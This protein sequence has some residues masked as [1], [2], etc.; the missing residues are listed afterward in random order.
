MIFNVMDTVAV[1]RDVNN[2]DWMTARLKIVLSPYG[3]AV[4][5]FISGMGPA[6]EL[7]P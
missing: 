1:A 3:S 6:P 5:A 4:L 7:K 2:N